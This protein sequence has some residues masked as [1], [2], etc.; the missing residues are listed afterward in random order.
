[1]RTRDWAC[2]WCGY[3]LLSSSYREIPKTYQELKEEGL[4]KQEAPVEEEAGESQVPGHDTVSPVETPEPELEAVPEAEPAVEPQPEP[5]VEPEPVPKTRPK[6][7]SKS[8]RKPK[9]EPELESK[10]EVEEAAEAEPEPGPSP[11]VLEVTVEE[12]S[13]AFAEDPASTDE[14]LANKVL[15][16]T[17]VVSRTIVDDVVEKPCLILTSTDKTV[18]KNVLCLFDKEREPELR[19]LAEG[20]T[21]TVKG[22]YDGYTINILVTDCALVG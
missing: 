8:R 3:P 15:R 16:I 7:V 11:T 6:R 17:G 2:Q 9:P 18:T 22:K 5:A 4:H 14:R 1:M 10:P 20:Q 13:S 21:V 12:L 19:R